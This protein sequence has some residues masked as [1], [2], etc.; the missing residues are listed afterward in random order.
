M[1]FSNENFDPMKRNKSRAD[2]DLSDIP[3]VRSKVAEL[4]GVIVLFKGKQGD[5]AVLKLYKEAPEVEIAVEGVPVEEG[6]NVLL[7]NSE[8]GGIP[9]AFGI[10]Y[11]DANFGVIEKNI[12]ARNLTDR[13]IAANL[14]VQNVQLLDGDE[15]SLQ[16]DSLDVVVITPKAYD[17]QDLLAS[18]IQAVQRALRVGGAIY[19]ITHK[20]RG[21]ESQLDILKNIVG[22][23]SIVDRGRGGFRI[24]AA[25]KLNATELETRNLRKRI[26]FSVLG[27]DVSLDTELSLFSHQD[28]DKGTRVLLETIP[29]DVYANFNRALDLGCGWGAI[30]ITAALAN[31]DGEVVMT[32]VDGRAVQVASD[33]AHTLGL[34]DRVSAVATDDI[35]E[36]PGNFDLIL[37]NPPFHENNRTLLDLF[38]RVRNKLTKGGELYIVVER[39]YHRKFV[40]ILRDT[41]GET[42][43]QTITE[44]TNGFYVVRA[45]KSGGRKNYSG[46][47]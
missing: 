44:E 38:G 17:S 1:N 34:E 11:P 32:D 29:A 23:G 39:T 15:A 20:K 18:Q 8:D 5:R 35:F 40:D 16:P 14:Q 3:T 43:V 7:I 24:L 6:D 41:F 21:A 26:T 9:V 13:N 30:G 25:R 36:I 47:I 10:V 27:M 2:D 22:N 33:N 19:V 31:P 37:S 46:R 12:T 4:D 42:S 28:L 45:V